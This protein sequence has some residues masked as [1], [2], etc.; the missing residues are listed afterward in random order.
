MCLGP[1]K[2]VLSVLLQNPRE[3]IPRAIEKR[4]KPV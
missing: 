1:E 3:F 4:L 2:S